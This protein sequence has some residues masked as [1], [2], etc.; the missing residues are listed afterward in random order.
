MFVLQYLFISVLNCAYIPNTYVYYFYSDLFLICIKSLPLTLL[1]DCAE[2]LVAIILWLFFQ[3]WQFQQRDIRMTVQL[4]KHVF[5]LTDA[6]F[7]AVAVNF[8]YFLNWLM[9]LIRCSLTVNLNWF[10]ALSLICEHNFFIYFVLIHRPS[11]RSDSSRC[12][13]NRAHYT[14]LVVFSESSPKSLWKNCF[15]KNVFKICDKIEYSEQRPIII[16][17]EEIIHQPSW[18]EL[19]LDQLIIQTNH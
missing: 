11:E 14:L 4:S 16:I 13:T 10:V 1:S 6:D 9:K 8:N 15:C 17:I 19:R 5:D 7:W 2:I 3:I 12:I 18:Y